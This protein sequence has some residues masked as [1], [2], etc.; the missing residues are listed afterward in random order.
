MSQNREGFNPNA[1]TTNTGTDAGTGSSGPGS[2]SSGS[3]ST[4]TATA[5]TQTAQDYGH[6]ISEAATQAKDYVSDKVSVVG[7]KLKELQDADLGEV[8]ANAKEYARKNPGQAILI[9][10]A[11]GLVLGLILR[12]RRQ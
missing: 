11:A 7:D 3:G 9:S 4:G 12:G 6:K 2:S 5:L 8:A 10:A 1:P